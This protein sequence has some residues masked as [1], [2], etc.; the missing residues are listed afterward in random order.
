M[1]YDFPTIS[2]TVANLGNNTLGYLWGTLDYETG[3]LFTVLF[4]T[5]ILVVIGIKTQNINAVAVVSGIL[6]AL[7]LSYHLFTPFANL[8]LAGIVA[9][10]VANGI[11][12]VFFKKRGG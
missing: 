3:G 8:Y 6:L 5:A 11:Y 7:N 1:A 12:K 9:L 10:A 4:I 2:D